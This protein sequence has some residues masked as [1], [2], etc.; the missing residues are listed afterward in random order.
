MNWKWPRPPRLCETYTGERRE[1]IKTADGRWTWSPK[2]SIPER[3]LKPEEAQRK[4]NFYLVYTE[5]GK[6]QEPKV[7][8]KTFE[9]AIAAARA[10]QRHLED[11]ADGYS[12]PDPLKKVERKKISEAIEDRLRRDRVEK[13]HARPKLHVVRRPENVGD[14]PVAAAMTN[15]VHSTRRGPGPIYS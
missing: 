10:K 15:R 1:R 9:A 7:K 11:A 8:G 4:G 13:R 3:K 2:I 6:K 14:R 12:R 5:R